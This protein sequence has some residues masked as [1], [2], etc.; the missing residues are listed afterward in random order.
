M[1]FRPP[2]RR[3]R[4]DNIVVGLLTHAAG[5]AT[6]TGAVIVAMLEQALWPLV[7]GG[8]ALSVMESARLYYRLRP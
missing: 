5:L 8:V 3:N 6:V 7:V 4:F 1:K 2:R